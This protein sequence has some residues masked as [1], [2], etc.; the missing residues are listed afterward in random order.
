MRSVLYFRGVSSARSTCSAS[1][2]FPSSRYSRYFCCRSR[3]FMRWTHRRIAVRTLIQ[4][5]AEDQRCVT[6]TTTALG[7]CISAFS[8]LRS[9][10][11]WQNTHTHINWAFTCSQTLIC[12]LFGSLWPTWPLQTQKGQSLETHKGVILLAI[13]GNHKQFNDS[14][15]S[16][17][18]SE[19]F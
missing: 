18:S 5:C 1:R 9:L 16:S 12:C 3:N 14:G 17:D 2:I 11:A 6:L 4:R 7:E 8:S 10:S 13:Y 15:S 19:L